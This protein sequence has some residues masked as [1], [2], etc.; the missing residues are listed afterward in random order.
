[1]AKTCKCGNQTNNVDGVCAGCKVKNSVKEQYDNLRSKGLIE[2]KDYDVP[3]D[4]NKKKVNY[5]T[6]KCQRCE[7]DYL[8]T[9]R[10]Q[11]FC[12]ECQKDKQKEYQRDYLKRK[13]DKKNPPRV[14]QGKS[15]SIDKS[16]DT[17]KVP[18]NNIEDIG[19]RVGGDSEPGGITYYKSP[20][21]KVL[22]GQLLYASD[23]LDSLIDM[24]T[25]K[26][27][28]DTSVLIDIRK[29]IGI[30]LRESLEVH[31]EASL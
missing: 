28:T 17:S 18:D 8:P 13:R 16:V 2:E 31:G 6:R 5:K 9:N 21:P 23:L 14:L 24:A 30:V 3:Y 26:N 29:R 4:P 10:N 15:K 25:E 27:E 22:L 19:P 12:V 1:M 20:D 7:V 11:K